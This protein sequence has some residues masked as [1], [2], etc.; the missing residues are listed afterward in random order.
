MWTRKSDEQLA[1]EHSR[2]WLSFRGPA[3]LFLCC[4]VVGIV[5]AFT[6]YYQHPPRMERPKSWERIVGR[7]IFV[8]TVVALSGYVLQIA[9]RRKIRPWEFGLRVVMCD[10]C[11][12]VKR[13]D[14]EE[15][16][17]C[18]GVFD[19]FDNWTWVDDGEGDNGV[20]E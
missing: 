4:F 19:N 12:R 8:G 6:P 10:K 13:R 17:A 11:Y 1:R 18:G 16:C 14:H 3:F 7:A 9:L 2:P 20:E 15:K 5:A